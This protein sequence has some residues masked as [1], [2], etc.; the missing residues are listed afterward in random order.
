LSRGDIEQDTAQAGKGRG[1]GDKEAHIAPSSLSIEGY[2]C[3]LGGK[4]TTGLGTNDPS[5]SSLASS[6]TST[7]EQPEDPSSSCAPTPL[8][9]QNFGD[10]AVAFFFHQYIVGA[11]EN[12]CA[13]FREFFPELYNLD[14]PNEALAH[15]IK[16]I[17]YISLSAESS[18]K[19]LAAGDHEH[20]RISLPKISHMLQSAEET[21]Q[22][23]LIVVIMLVVL[24]E[25]RLSLGY[26]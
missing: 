15:S 18:V 1:G 5:A 12:R 3:R 19:V 23:S 9:R 16:A 24:F 26:I 8:P 7:A 10:Q 21:A 6:E 2:D 14:R 22:D 20:Y 25:V 13:G 17:S 11:S 4:E